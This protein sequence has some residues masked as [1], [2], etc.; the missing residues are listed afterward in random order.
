MLILGK[1]NAPKRLFLMLGYKTAFPRCNRTLSLTA[2][3]SSQQSHRN[4]CPFPPFSSARKSQS[5]QWSWNEH[6][7]LNGSHR[8]VLAGRGGEALVPCLVK[9]RLHSAAVMLSQRGVEEPPWHVPRTRCWWKRLISFLK[10]SSG[11]RVIL[12]NNLYL[13]VVSVFH[14]FLGVAVIHHSNCLSLVT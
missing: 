14:I 10:S 5:P 13:R 7:E 3:H 1:Q 2:F 6:M 11:P 12:C 4:K 9:K 8:W